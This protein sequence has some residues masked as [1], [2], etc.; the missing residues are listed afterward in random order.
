MVKENVDKERFDS[1]IMMLTDLSQN[2]LSVM[3][4]VN[5][6]T[7]RLLSECKGESFS[8]LEKKYDMICENYYRLYVRLADMGNELAV[9]YEEAHQAVDEKNKD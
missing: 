7:E 2:I 6:L 1:M 4:N 5:D 9:H 3:D 8:R